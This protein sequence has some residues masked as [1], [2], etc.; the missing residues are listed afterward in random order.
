MLIHMSLAGLIYM[1][2][3]ETDIMKYDDGNNKGKVIVLLTWNKVG[4]ENVH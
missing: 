4:H 2:I 3:H 1:S